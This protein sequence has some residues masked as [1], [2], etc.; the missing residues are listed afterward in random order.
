M[1][2]QPFT[3]RSDFARRA[4]SRQDTQ[5]MTSANVTMQARIS[6]EGEE[7]DITETL[8]VID[9]ARRFIKQNHDSISGKGT[10]EDDAC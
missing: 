5:V 2:D 6:T 1:E 7:A 10:E 8:R 3:L 9:S 4:S